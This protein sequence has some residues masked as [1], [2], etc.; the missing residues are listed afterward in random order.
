M[1][2]ELSA[3]KIQD[4]SPDLTR[5]DAPGSSLHHI[6]PHAEEQSGDRLNCSQGEK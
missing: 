2:D 3:K 6:A 5:P 4:F 1:Q